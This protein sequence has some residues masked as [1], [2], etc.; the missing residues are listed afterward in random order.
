MATP[1]TL[2]GNSLGASSS[3]CRNHVGLTCTQLVKKLERAEGELQRLQLKVECRPVPYYKVVSEF[4]SDKLNNFVEP[5]H[6]CTCNVCCL[7]IETIKKTAVEAALAKADEARLTAGSAAE[8]G[9]KLT[10]EESKNNT[11]DQQLSEAPRKSSL[12]VNQQEH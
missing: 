1:A 2:R 4:F 8:G 3:G 9:G 6:Q 10:H 11:P 5:S 12:L 7:D